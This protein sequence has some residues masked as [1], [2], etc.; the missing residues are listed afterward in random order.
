MIRLLCGIL[1]VCFLAGIDGVP[2]AQANDDSFM[3]KIKGLE[4]KKLSGLQ[5]EGLLTGNTLYVN[6]TNRQRRMRNIWLYFK[7]GKTLD[8]Y[9]H[10]E[11]AKSWGVTTY[12]NRRWNVKGDGEICWE[13]P[14]N[15]GV[16]L[17]WAN[18]RIEKGML[19]VNGLRGTTDREYKVIQ[20]KRF[21][22]E[23][24]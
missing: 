10:N 24:Q 20:R 18:P 19:K 22:P 6:W 12:E 7:D 23:K 21:G 8:S 4:G 2:F 17:C 3:A 9:H 1:F 13:E 11:R 14:N 5:L 16:F 15:V